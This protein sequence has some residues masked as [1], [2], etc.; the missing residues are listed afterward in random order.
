[1]VEKG[2]AGEGGWGAREEEQQGRRPAVGESRAEVLLYTF[3]N[4]PGR[5][6]GKCCLSAKHGS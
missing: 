6:K 4:F 1:M 3:Q 5:E 2:R